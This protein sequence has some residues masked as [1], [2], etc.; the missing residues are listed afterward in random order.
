MSQ[1]N[2]GFLPYGRQSIDAD[3]ITAVVKVL[4][5]D[6]LTTGPAVLAFE[7]AFASKVGARYAVACSS[8]T[9]ALHLTSLA[10]GL[11]TDDTTIVPTITF[12]ATAN[13]ARY[14]NATVVFSDVNPDTGLMD[15][16]HL[17]NALRKCSGPVPKAVFPVHLSGQ[18]VNMEEISDVAAEYNMRIVEDASHALGSEY[19]LASGEKALV[20][21]CRHSDMTVF[22][23][24]PVK[25]IAMGEGGAV[26]T[27]DE[28]LYAKLLTFRNHGMIHEPAAM[29]NTDMARSISGEP[30]PWYYEMPDL[31]FNYRASDIHCALG[32][33]QLQK[34]DVFVATRRQLASHYDKLLGSADLPL[35]PTPRL[36]HCNPALHLY[37][38][39]VDFSA[40][41]MDRRDL[42]LQLRAK[43]IGTQVHYIPVHRQPYYQRLYGKSDLPNADRYYE[44]ELSLPLYASMTTD[45]VDH[46]VQTLR[47]VILVNNAADKG[48][49]L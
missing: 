40:L 12:L 6:W 31:G 32:L 15:K 5:G 46:V 28:E 41:N 13:A 14:V 25:T 34:L 21:S 43:G 23:F 38:V 10:L 27:N 11:T 7:E 47:D 2:S 45:D 44:R 18:T 22:S 30:N 26:T 24:H 4:Q 16:E 42:M 17:Q 36:D 48:E 8:G 29:E 1:K 35:V 20:G 9:A 39:L 33:S 3:D 37:P 49:R 19:T